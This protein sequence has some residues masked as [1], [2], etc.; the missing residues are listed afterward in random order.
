MKTKNYSAHVAEQAIYMLIAKL[1]ELFN[2]GQL[3]QSKLLKKQEFLENH[4]ANNEKFD[5][6]REDVLENLKMVMKEKT[7]ANTK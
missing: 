4:D 6:I 1:A 2:N 5:M 7:M 3:L